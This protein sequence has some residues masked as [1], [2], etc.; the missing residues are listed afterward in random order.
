MGA[1][2]QTRATQ[3]LGQGSLRRRPVWR[4][5]GVA[6]HGG[7]ASLGIVKHNLAP[8]RWR[9]R[10]VGGRPSP[11]RERSAPRPGRFCSAVCAAGAPSRSVRPRFRL[12]APSTGPS[13]RA[14]PFV[15][16]STERKPGLHRL[17]AGGRWIRTFGPWR[18]GAVSGEAARQCSGPARMQPAAPVRLSRRREAVPGKA[19]TY[20]DAARSG[21]EVTCVRHKRP[22]CHWPSFLGPA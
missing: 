22:A 9:R 11:S 19:R 12:P 7:L 8:A 1:R 14:C 5:R 15:R 10:S 21:C 20:P 6:E 13:C 17:S 4:R 16:G 18:G 2:R 3:C